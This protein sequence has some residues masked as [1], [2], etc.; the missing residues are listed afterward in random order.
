MAHPN[1]LRCF[2]FNRKV[3]APG[4]IP[5]PCLSVLRVSLGGIKGHPDYQNFAATVDGKALR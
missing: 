4:Q 1:L 2:S 5:W 3:A